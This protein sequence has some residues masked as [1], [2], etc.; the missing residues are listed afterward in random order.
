MSATSNTFEVVGLTGVSAQ[1]F[2]VGGLNKVYILD[3]VENNPTKLEGTD[4][5]AWATEY[6]LR[7]NT[8]R[9]MPVETNTF[10]AGG[11]ALGNG[12][13]ISVGGNKAVTFGGLDGKNAVA[14]YYNDDGAKSIRLITPCDN[15]NDCQWSV[16]P[17]GT[18]MQ[19]KRWYPTVETLEDGSAI[20]IGGCTDGGYVN[21]ANQNVP[22]IE[23]FPSKGSAIG[24]NFLTTT[25]PANLYT[26]T[27]LL[28]S[29]N[30]FLQTNLATEIFDYKKN[31]EYPLPNIPH[32][33]RTYPASA[34][35]AMLP[36]T[37]KNNYTATILFCGGTN[38]QPDQWQTNWNIAA[39]P[40][41]SSCVKMTPDVSGNWEDEDSL[42][43]GRSMGQF[44]IMPDGRLWMGNGIAKGTAGY[45]N[46]SWAIGQSFGNNPIL[47]PAY[48]DPQAPKGSRWSRPMS[49]ATV[50][51]LYHSVASLL[52][53]GSIL[54]AGSNPNADYI[55]P[56]TANY[57]FV[58]EYR[59]EKFYPDYYTKT[60]PKPSELPKSLSYGG[61]YF[62][63]TLSSSDLGNGAKL[64]SAFVSIVRLGYS[65]HAMNMGQR[66][67]QLNSTY[68]PNSGGS[69][70][71]HV[72]QMP[73][74]V[75]CFPP[76]PAMMFVVV[77]GVPS[78]GSM[79]MIG[80]GQIGDQPVLNAAPL[81][82]QITDWTS[83]S[84]G[85]AQDKAKHQSSVGRFNPQ[86]KIIIAI[87]IVF[88]VLLSN[89]LR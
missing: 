4:R 12:S 21:D 48:F 36:L 84:S 65:T 8:F 38:L 53:D 64:S 30:L 23:Y 24:L 47:A 1:Q 86:E 78:M 58:T 22:T 49:N 82:G 41:D 26:L 18:I 19:A 29:G 56:G 70:T 20:I 81:P 88:N 32:A 44:V 54:T 10:C 87:L 46:T 42:F 67:L 15:D 25:L 57:P 3:K 2:F 52:A 9:T 60:R 72:S 28:P 11:T 16:N 74:C 45:G 75:A 34:A 59:A 85:A 69:G 73:P 76:G 31:I 63:I 39:Y 27:W 14:P 89:N 77:A 6:D 50:P 43:E 66:Y 68:S 37:P 51:R 40:T 80:N 17:G 7:T 71:L 55:A 5:P 79:V 35:T 83:T 13:W 33:V 62:N 61:D